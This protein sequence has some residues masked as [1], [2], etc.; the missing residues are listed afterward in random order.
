MQYLSRALLALPLAL[1]LGTAAR[2]ADETPKT[3]DYYPLKVGNVWIYKI[4][5]V[6]FEM[7]VKSFESVDGQLCARIE[8]SVNGNPQAVEHVAVK[9]DGVYRYKFQDKKA[10]PAV[11]FLKL[12]PAPCETWE[13]SSSIG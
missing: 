9:D 13:V 1:A 5:D 6:K 7:R 8:M 4:S 11:P 2:A 3:S 12:P 10:E